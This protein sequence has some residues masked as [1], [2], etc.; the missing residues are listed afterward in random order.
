MTQHISLEDF[1]IRFT[2]QTQHDRIMVLNIFVDDEHNYNDELY[3]K[4]VTSSLEHNFKLYED[5]FY[6]DAGFDLFLPRYV[7]D[8]QHGGQTLYNTGLCGDKNICSN[9]VDFRIR[10]SAKMLYIY[11]MKSYDTGYYIY[12]RSSIS[13][14]PLRL[15]NNTGIIDAGYRGHIIGMFDN[16]KDD[17]YV[18]PHTRLIQICAPNLVPIYI[19]IVDSLDQL[20]PSTRRGDGG[21]GS[22]GI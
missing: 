2:T 7:D 21:F 16:L 19:N 9:K 13:K 4:Y 12:P 15:A 11:N 22:T 8:E 6:Y 10:C 17:Y 3:T 5:P 14:T 1:S 20:G 18:E